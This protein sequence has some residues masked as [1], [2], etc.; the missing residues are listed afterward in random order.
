MLRIRLLVSS[1][2]ELRRLTAP[3]ALFRLT[4][5]YDERK[6][7]TDLPFLRSPSLHWLG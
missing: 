3:R 7:L 4:L 1:R 5:S 2:L 6:V